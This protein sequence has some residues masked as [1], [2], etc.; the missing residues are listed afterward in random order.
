MTNVSIGS[1]PLAGTTVSL[2][3]GSTLVGAPTLVAR[4]AAIS[5]RPS[6]P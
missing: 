3:K 1:N 5:T 6:P 2:M 4:A